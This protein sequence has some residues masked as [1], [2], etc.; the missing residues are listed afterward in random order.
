MS[1]KFDNI[2][3]VP[4]EAPQAA[5]IGTDPNCDIDTPSTDPRCDDPIYRL[6]HPDECDKFTYLIVKP[7]VITMCLLQELRFKAFLVTDGEEVELVNG[8]TWSTNDPATV[9]VSVVN[10]TVT[11]LKEGIAVVCASYQ[12][13]SACSHI[14][15]IDPCCE[16][17]KVGIVLAVDKS[18]SMGQLFSDTQGTKLAFAKNILTRW[19]DAFFWQ[20]DVVMLQ[21]FDYE[22]ETIVDWTQDTNA[23]KTG[24][25]TLSASGTSDIQDALLEA[26]AALDARTDLDLKGI[27]LVTDGFYN[28]WVKKFDDIDGLAPFREF[29]ERGGVI[30]V[31]A[32]RSWGE[33]YATMA[34]VSSAGFFLSAHEST[35]TNITNWLLHLSGYFCG[36][37]CKPVGDIIL[38][39]RASPNYTGFKNFDVF[40]PSGGLPVDYPG[41]VDLCGGFPEFPGYA[42]YDLLP[43]NGLYV[44]LRG[45]PGDGGLVTKNEWT[46][47][48]G[49]EYTITVRLAGNQRNLKQ[50]DT[51]R[52]SIGSF[53]VQEITLAPDSPFT[54]YTY[55][56][57]PTDAHV[58]KM[59]IEIVPDQTAWWDVGPLLDRVYVFEK[60]TYIGIPDAVLI[61][62]NFDTEN[63]GYIPPECEWG[64]PRIVS[65]PG[66]VSPVLGP[67]LAYDCYGYGCLFDA[68][69]AQTADPSPQTEI[70]EGENT[71]ASQESALYFN[72]A[73]IFMTEEAI[74]DE[75]ELNLELTGGS[76]QGPITLLDPPT[77]PLHMTNKAYVDEGIGGADEYSESALGVTNGTMSFRF[78]E[79][80][81]STGNPLVLPAA[82]IPIELLDG[83]TYQFTVLVAARRLDAAGESA[84][85]KVDGVVYRKELTTAI[86]GITSKM[87]LTPTHWDCDVEA[88]DSQASLQLVVTG[89]PDKVVRWA[90]G[91][92]L[93]KIAA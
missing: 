49:F 29:K 62:D 35:E 50:T 28:Q 75:M 11:A 73:G 72:P 44:D 80:T 63:G 14:T 33:A 58:G 53:W 46:F 79:G 26:I 61:D 24:I 4:C 81:T 7:D 56:W 88:N 8:V 36:G 6:Q 60:S 45:T 68:I 71:S 82:P 91:W 69:P 15:V 12:Q 67:D 66:T 16:D 31:V 76:M 22:S 17:K 47:S 38:P 93:T 37:F 21:A 34:K 57:I 90:A 42:W 87:A 78:S 83:E 25:A 30:L 10:G 48:A 23:I 5:L 52:V 89:Q 9:S 27:I 74:L 13:V 86:S 92:S 18:L 65:S 55:T 19:S 59:K 3:T 20:K 43:G 84:G 70:N 1:L 64:D 32:L 39:G 85:F 2:I 40:K 77:L 51:V 54:D 41:Q